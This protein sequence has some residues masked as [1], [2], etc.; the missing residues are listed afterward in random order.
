MIG[1][2]A[3]AMG[4]GLL[5]LDQLLDIRLADRAVHLTGGGGIAAA[6]ASIVKHPGRMLG[7]DQ[8]QMIGLVDQPG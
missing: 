3:D 2:N 7:G 1:I 8:P 4:Q 6:H 5:L